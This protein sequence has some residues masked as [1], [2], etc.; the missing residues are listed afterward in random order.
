MLRTGAKPS[1][2]DRLDEHFYILLHYEIEQSVTALKKANFSSMNGTN[3]DPL[4][5]GLEDLF[6]N[7]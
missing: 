1:K 2:L 7:L 6:M 5:S 4:I 3:S